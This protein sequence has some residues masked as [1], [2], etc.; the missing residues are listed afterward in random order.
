MLGDDAE[1]E[2][3]AGVLTGCCRSANRGWEMKPWVLQ[4]LVDE[5]EGATHEGACMMLVLLFFCEENAGKEN[6]TL[7][8]TI[9]SCLYVVTTLGLDILIMRY[10]HSVPIGHPL[11]TRYRICKI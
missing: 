6:K 1:L 4:E 8:F 5:A 11:T 9:F 3:V 7:T 10:V 2:G